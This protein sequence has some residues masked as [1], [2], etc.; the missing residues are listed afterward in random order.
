MVTLLI[1]SVLGRMAK[2]TLGRWSPR[3]RSRGRALDRLARHSQDA[4]DLRVLAAT[5]EGAAADARGA[6]RAWLLV[7]WGDGLHFSPPSRQGNNGLS[8]IKLSSTGALVTWLRHRD[9][10]MTRRELEGQ[11][12]GPATSEELT[13]LDRVQVQ[14]LVPLS[15]RGELAGVLALGP[16]TSGKPYSRHDLSGLRVLA[17]KTAPWVSNA[18]LATSLGFQRN[19]LERLL[20]QSVN[21]GETER[22]RMAM[23]LHDS[24]VQWLTSA[25]YHVEAC[26]ET[27]CRGEH[28]KAARD[29]QE[30]Q[31]A[32][33][34][35]LEELRHTAAA[36]H[37]PDLEQVGL[38]R[39][40]AR[41]ADVFE[42]DTGVLTTFRE[43]QPVPR[44]PDLLELAAYRVV[45]E[46]MSNVRKH[47]RATEV[48]LDIGLGNG[49][50][51]VTVKDNG[52]GFLADGDGPAGDGHLGLVGMEERAYMASGSLGITSALG[53][54]TEITLL[55]PYVQT[56]SAF[57]PGVEEPEEAQADTI[58]EPR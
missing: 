25:V 51:W 39:A 57:D 43:H 56:L 41:H 17:A 45:Q 19:R 3:R 7:P 31:Y 46:A 12:G 23:D 55:L 27:F 49:I 15:H 47:A 34:K 28:G 16:R 6:S 5:I 13:H 20:E 21:A 33:N 2:A 32:L 44:L 40:L 14:L 36:L 10:P 58:V 1:Q 29:L 30:I 8:P 35:T 9:G 4:A 53:K 38:A 26:L 22:R 54:G 48:R 24:P 18:N 11:S 50:L 42:R 37:P 52:V